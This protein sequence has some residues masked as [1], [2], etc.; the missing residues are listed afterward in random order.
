MVDPDLGNSISSK[1]PQG[2][3]SSLEVGKKDGNSDCFLSK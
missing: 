2:F 3:K 1:M